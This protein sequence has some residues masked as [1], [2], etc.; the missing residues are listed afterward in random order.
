MKGDMGVSEVD[1]FCFFESV[2]GNFANI[3]D[4]PGDSGV[5]T[6]I[7]AMEKCSDSSAIDQMIKPL[8]EL[9]SGAIGA[10]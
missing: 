9:A 7:E 3:S 6:K 5:L 1:V 2:G 8:G 4:D 10:P